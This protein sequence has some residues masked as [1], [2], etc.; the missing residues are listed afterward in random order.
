M[1]PDV[2]GK[3]YVRI[4]MKPVISVVMSVYNGEANLGETINSVLSQSFHVFEFVIVDDGST[5]RTPEML[6]ELN[7]RYEKIQTFRNRENLGLTKSLNTGIRE[8]KGE[9]IARIDCADLW[10]PRKLERQISYLRSH[11]ETILLGTQAIYLNERGCESGRSRL[12]VTDEGIRLLFMRSRNPFLHSSVV[13]KAGYYYDERLN[14]SQDYELWMRLFFEGKMANLT[15]PLVMCRLLRNNS[16]SYENRPK[17]IC[18]NWILYER[19]VKA[20]R[21]KRRE[22]NV[23]RRVPYEK[24]ARIRNSS[25]FSYLN[26]LGNRLKSTSVLL[27]LLLVAFSYTI[28]PSLLCVTIWHRLKVLIS[29]PGLKRALRSTKTDIFYSDS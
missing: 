9:Y 13:F 4:E 18:L 19:F 27:G 22:E 12:P 7:R 6:K 14:S 5:D 11:P 26:Y 3:V 25:M 28:H 16:I 24:L 29:A 15:S 10:K 20:L 23:E 2:G 8:S 17:Q 1:F 21:N